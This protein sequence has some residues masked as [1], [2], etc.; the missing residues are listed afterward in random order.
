MIYFVVEKF[1]KIRRTVL[2]EYYDDFIL[3]LR[4]R[5]LSWICLEKNPF[6]I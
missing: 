4:R 5:I 6:K 2:S 1:D 3:Y